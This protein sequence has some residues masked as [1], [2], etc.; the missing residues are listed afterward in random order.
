MN[1]LLTGHGRLGVPLAQRLGAL[2]HRVRILS[3]TPRDEAPWDVAVGRLDRADDVLAAADGCDLIVHNG[4]IIERDHDFARHEQFVATNVGGSANVFRAAVTV[5]ARHVVHLSSD[6]ALDRPTA[7]EVDAAGRAH[8]VRDG[9]PPT[10]GGLYGL[11]KSLAEQLGRYYRDRHGLSLT[12]LRPGWFPEPGELA[13]HEFAYRLLGSCVWVGDV[14][15]AVLAAIENPA[16]GAFL[17]HAATPFA[18]ADAVEMLCDPAAVLRRYWPE[19]AEWWLGQGLATPPIRQWA[20]I[21]PAR[22]SLG[23]A[24]TLD[25]ARAVARLRDG[26]SPWPTAGVQLAR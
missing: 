23:Y 10:R 24:P 20:D 17:I 25:F 5:G 11:T 8:C 15:A 22:Q 12:I 26:K 18:D 7:E 2:G 3:R 6:A 21:T 13:D 9:D 4:A 14:I 19:E 16:Q 1:I